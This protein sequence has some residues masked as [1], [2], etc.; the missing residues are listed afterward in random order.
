MG[1]YLLRRLAISV[2]VLIGITLVT[3]FIINLAPGD[4][5]SAM[6]NPEA[7][8]ELGPEW[9]ENQRRA[10]GLDQPLP[11]RYVIWIG[12][13]A[14]GNLG[15]SYLDRQPVTDKIA[16]RVWPTLRLM[17]TVQVLALTIAVPIGILSAL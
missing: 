4:P 7:A 15:F 1:Q 3:F 8:A 6:I 16:E 11:V 12:E 13:L 14:K 10:L 2:P 9:F 17:L 5:V